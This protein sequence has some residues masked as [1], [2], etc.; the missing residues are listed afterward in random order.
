MGILTQFLRRPGNTG[1]IAPSTRALADQMLSWIDFATVDTIV[2]YGPG[3]GVF[4]REIIARMKP[5][6]VFIVI[7]NNESLFKPLV[8]EFP[9]AK[10]HHASAADVGAILNE[11]GREKADAVV[12]GLPWASFPAELQA[13]ILDSTLASLKDGGQFCTFAYLQGLLLGAGRRFR[14]ELQ[15]RFETVN[16]SR[17]VWLNVPPAFVYQ[18]VR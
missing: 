2:E 3:T 10:V 14:R 17:T 4:T 11:H 15:S 1:A 8:A 9:S 18:C 16:R 13:A 6:T 7:E 5:D 12:S